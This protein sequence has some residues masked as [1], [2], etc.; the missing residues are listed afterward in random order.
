LAGRDFTWPQ[1]NRIYGIGGMPDPPDNYRGK[2][3]FILD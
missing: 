1:G 3:G 2:Y